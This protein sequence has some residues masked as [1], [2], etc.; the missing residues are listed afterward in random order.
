MVDKLIIKLMG[1]GCG[2]VGRAAASSVEILGSNLGNGVFY[3][4]KQS[5]MFGVHAKPP[6]SAHDWSLP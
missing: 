5:T 4:F 2:S 1:S 6:T 3:T